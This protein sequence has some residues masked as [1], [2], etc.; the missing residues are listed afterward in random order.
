LIHAHSLSHSAF[1]LATASSALYV[2]WK[3]SHAARD[4]SSISRTAQS[5]IFVSIQ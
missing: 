1:F 5:D 4:L 2:S 3:L